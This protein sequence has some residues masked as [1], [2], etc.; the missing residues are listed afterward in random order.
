MAYDFPV[1]TQ[2]MGG[3]DQMLGSASHRGARH[4]L[5]QPRW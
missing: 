1:A 2:V 4:K 3:M 5:V